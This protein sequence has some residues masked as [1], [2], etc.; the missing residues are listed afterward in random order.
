MNKAHVGV[1]NIYKKYD[2]N[3][4][5]NFDYTHGGKIFNYRYSYNAIFSEK[6]GGVYILNIDGTAEEREAIANNQSIGKN[7]VVIIDYR[8]DPNNPNMQVR[9]STKITDKDAIYGIIDI[10]VK[11]EDKYPSNGNRSEDSLYSEWIWHNRMNSVS[12]ITDPIKVTNG[13]KNR[14]QHVDLDN[15]G[16]NIFPANKL[17]EFSY[18]IN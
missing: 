10:L 17:P 13:W 11:Y 4:K 14:T 6:S 12:Q 3:Y 18:Y 15:N 8:D 7:D 16:E 2:A 1:V 9:D 5:D